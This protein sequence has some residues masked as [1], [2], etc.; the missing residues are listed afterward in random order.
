MPNHIVHILYTA[1]AAQD[2]FWGMF[3]QGC[4]SGLGGGKRTAM[5]TQ[6]TL[7]E[8]LAAET[9]L[10]KLREQSLHI[11]TEQTEKHMAETVGHSGGGVYKT[12]FM[13]LY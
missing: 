11:Y 1:Q 3:A 8:I 6:G 2:G 7:S 5:Q 4:V 13:G 9:Q 10:L 12:C